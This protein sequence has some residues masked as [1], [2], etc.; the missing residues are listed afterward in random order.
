M[1]C[2]PMRLG[3]DLVAAAGRRTRTTPCP[4]PLSPSCC[5]IVRRVGLRYVG[6]LVAQRYRRLGSEKLTID[7][8]VALPQPDVDVALLRPCC[9]PKCKTEPHGRAAQLC[10]SA[11]VTTKPCL[12]EAE[13]ASDSGY[14]Y[15]AHRC[16]L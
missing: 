13:I 6:I 8:Q 9:R 4:H 7:G 3:L 10:L 2:L 15:V 12:A 16:D 11:K 14:V 5:E 1:K